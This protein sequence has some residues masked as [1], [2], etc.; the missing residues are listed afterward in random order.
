MASVADRPIGGFIA[1]LSARTAIPGGG[2]AAA[3]AAA[4][5]CAAGAMAARYTTGPKWADRAVAA[6][7]L[8][9]SL[10]A[11][12]A[13]ALALASEDELAFSAAQAARSAKDAVA[14]AAAEAR[15][16]VIPL[17]IARMCAD[18][19]EAL[20]QFLPQCNPQLVSDVHVGIHLLAGAARAA[21]ATVAANNPP[22]EIK[23][24][25]AALLERCAASERQISCR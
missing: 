16:G 21:C 18:Q 23:A 9:C 12:A 8:A 1:S 19:V 20:A 13:H 10:D 22:A 11:T 4:L 24:A 14:I 2:A 7:A 17:S 6:E 5:G 15:A 25:S 3:I